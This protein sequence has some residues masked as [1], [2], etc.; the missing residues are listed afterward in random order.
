MSV[1]LKVKIPSKQTGCILSYKAS[2]T[3]SNSTN[4]QVVIELYGGHADSTS[5]AV[6]LCSRLSD[7]VD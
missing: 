1:A 3:N 5:S 6:R 7:D 2:G 4:I